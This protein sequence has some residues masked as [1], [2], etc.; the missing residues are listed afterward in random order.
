VKNFIGPGGE[1]KF[2]GTAKASGKLI[3]Q[4]DRVGMVVNTVASTETGVAKTWGQYTYAKLST[5]VVTAGASLWFDAGN[6]RLTL[7]STSNKFAGYALEDAGNG[8][9]SVAFELMGGHQADLT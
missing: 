3:V 8:V 1:F 4:G 5:D 6:D 2:T 7:T 9:T